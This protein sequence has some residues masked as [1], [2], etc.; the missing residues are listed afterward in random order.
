MY[1]LSEDIL[2]EKIFPSGLLII[3]VHWKK[4]LFSWL[5]VR[6]FLSRE[7]YDLQILSDPSKDPVTI[8]SPYLVEVETD[9]ILSVWP[10]SS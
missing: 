1:L 3:C 9:I 7:S 8:N 2:R 10:S 5:R 4:L 6:L